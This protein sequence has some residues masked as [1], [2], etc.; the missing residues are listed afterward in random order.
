MIFVPRT[1]VISEV[2]ALELKPLI[3]SIL[4]TDK[5]NFDL[6]DCDHILCLDSD[7]QIA[8]RISKHLKSYNSNC[9]ELE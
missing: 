3:D 1:S 7:Q 6:E 2:Q 4:P 5:W 8:Y 9:E